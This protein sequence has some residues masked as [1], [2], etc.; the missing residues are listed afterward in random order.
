[1]IIEKISILLKDNVMQKIEKIRISEDV[2]EV[3]QKKN[4]LRQYE[5]CEKY[6]KS[7]N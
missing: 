2:L 4:L 3:I 7:G 1:M 6:L 5:K